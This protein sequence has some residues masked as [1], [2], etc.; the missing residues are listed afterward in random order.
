[1]SKKII[2][3]DDEPLVLK[4]VGKLLEIEGYFVTTSESGKEALA[5]IEQEEI[6]LVI[7]DIRMPNM[8]GVE[9]ISIMIERCKDKKREAPPFIFITGYADEVVNQ[10]AQ[11]L[12]PADFIMK[13]F[14]QIDFLQSVKK[15]L[16]V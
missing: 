12:D 10:K 3:I 6:D 7:S 13:P 1:M 9:T 8:N 2:V 11:D 14:N 16:G 4:T 15:A 5:I